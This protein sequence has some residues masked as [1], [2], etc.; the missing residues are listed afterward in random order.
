MS[1]G[2]ATMSVASILAETA[3]RS[4]E[5]VALIFDGTE[6]SYG[7]LWEQ[8]LHYAGA[9]RD[10]GIGPDDRVALM[11][12]NVPDFPRVYYGA[13]ALGATVVPIHALLKAEEIAYVLQ[14]SGAALL[15]CAA[16]LLGEGAK[17]AAL[18]GIPVLSVLVLSLIH[19]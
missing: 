10:R 17:G 8:T 18:A 19:I 2:F 11:I 12:P 1:H 16:P 9:L 6:I 4:P 7:D 3:H 13:L 5:S 15:I 14:D